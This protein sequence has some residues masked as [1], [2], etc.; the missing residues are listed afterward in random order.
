MEPSIES[1]CRNILESV[2]QINGI[3][4]GR[5]R[6]EFGKDKQAVR[7][8]RKQ[9]GIIR[10]AARKIPDEFR[11]QHP[12]VKWKNLSA[13]RIVFVYEYFGIDVDAIWKIFLTALEEI[14]EDMQALIRMES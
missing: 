3:I 2:D 10:R 4:A 7:E 8:M 9:L 6:Q 12:E 1:E 14:K 13:I 11:N 5:S